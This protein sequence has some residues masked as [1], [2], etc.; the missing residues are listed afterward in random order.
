MQQ[1]RLILASERSYN[2]LR[3]PSIRNLRNILVRIAP[4]NGK[5][6]L[7]QGIITGY[8]N[9]IRYVLS[10][11]L[12]QRPCLGRIYIFAVVVRPYNC[13]TESEPSHF[14]Q[15]RQSIVICRES[16]CRIGISVRYFPFEYRCKP[17]QESGTAYRSAQRI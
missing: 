5:Q 3:G 16:S 13:R 11:L 4:Y 6:L 7:G 9:L 1:F 8:Y 10:H 17:F 15:I 12:F 2:E 14:I